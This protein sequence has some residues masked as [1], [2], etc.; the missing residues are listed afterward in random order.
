MA[1]YNDY[2]SSTGVESRNDFLQLLLSDMSYRLQGFGGTIE[3]D[4]YFELRKLSS[5][6]NLQ[7]VGRNLELRLAKQETANHYLCVLGRE[8]WALYDRT[9][10]CPLC[11]L[12]LYRP[13]KEI[14]EFESHNHLTPWLERSLAFDIL[15]ALDVN[16]D[17]VR[18]FGR[19]GAFHAF[20]DGEPDVEPVEFEEYIHW[21]WI[22]DNGA[23]IIIATENRLSHK[24]WSRFA[25]NNDKQ[26]LEGKLWN[27]LS[28]GELLALMVNH[29]SFVELH[30][31]FPSVGDGEALL[32]WSTILR[33]SK[34]YVGVPSAERRVLDPML[35]V[36][37]PWEIELLDLDP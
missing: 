14:R 34:G 37:E 27:Y 19:V 7:R 17:K 4:P 18:A 24:R 1:E 29:P 36:V 8:M 26:V 31:L 6:K 2:I 22:L 13:A 16:G 33:L 28:K 30:R 21:I 32:L 20:L 12:Q 25:W 3:L 9:Q 23:E 5:V 15:R 35:N 11:L 10:Q